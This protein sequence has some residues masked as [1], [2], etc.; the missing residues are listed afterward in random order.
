MNTG[1]VLV[2]WRGASPAATLNILHFV[3]PAWPGQKPIGRTF[4]QMTFPG[5]CGGGGGGGGGDVGGGGTSHSAR[6]GKR[7]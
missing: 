6:E 4:M 2:A 5:G 3:S 1:S 7:R